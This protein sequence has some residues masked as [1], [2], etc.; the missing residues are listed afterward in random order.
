MVMIIGL[1]QDW[2]V[3]IVFLYFKPSKYNGFTS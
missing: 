3:K 1:D 2:E